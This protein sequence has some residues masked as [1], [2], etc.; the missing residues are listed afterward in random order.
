MT[1]SSHLVAAAVAARRFLDEAGIRHC[2]IGGIAVQRW[3]EPRL[4]GDVDFTLF[5]PFG[6]E[7]SVL[8][9]LV[10]RFPARIPDAKSFALKNRVYL[11]IGDFG[12]PLDFAL[13]VMDFE[14]RMTERAIAFASRSGELKICSADD[15][16][17]LKAFAGRDKDWMDLKGILLRQGTK[18]NWP[19]ILA[20]LKPLAA[21]KESPELVDKLIALRDQTG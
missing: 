19:Q 11:G 17:V 10:Q 14:G 9:A 18:L 6:D 20:E 13:G 7:G 4:T 3:G 5:V 2:I 1:D 8:D 21:L 16:V 15:L 12:V